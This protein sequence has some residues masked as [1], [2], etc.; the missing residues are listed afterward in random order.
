MRALSIAATGMQAQ[1]LNVQTISN[2]IA[3]LNTTAFKKQ[4]AEFQDLLYQ[5]ITRVGT[6]SSDAATVIPTGIQVGLGVKTGATYRITEQGSLTQTGNAFDIAVLGQGYFQITLPSGDIAYTRAGSFQVNADGEIVTAEGY[7]VSP[8]ITVPPDAIQVDINQSGEVLVTIQ[9]QTTPSNVGQFDLAKFVN[10]AG[11]EAQGN[12]LFTETE[13]SG[14]PVL[15]TPG[16]DGFG[17]IQQ[18]FLETS[19]VD[20]VTEITNLIT[21]QRAYELNSRVISTA[22]EMLQ[23]INQIR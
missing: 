8:S 5:N 20:A 16:A 21:A 7:S 1:E 23:S 13:A 15:G 12:N 11:L 14:T 17:N 3:N 22:D 6:T 18:G 2:N 4:R 10:P 19:N 9:G